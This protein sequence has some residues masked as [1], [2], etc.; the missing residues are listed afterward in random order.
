MMSL[1]Q[2]R[3]FIAIAETG[4]VSAAASA[5]YISQSTLTTAIKQLEEELGVGLFERHAKGMEL[6]HLGHQ[7]LRQAYLIMGSVENAKRSLQQSTDDIAGVLNVGVTSMVAGYYLADLVARFKRVYHNISVRVVEDEREYIE[8]LIIGGELDVAVLMLSDLDNHF[9]FNTEVLTYSR[10]HIWLPPEHALL[11]EESLNMKSVLEEPQILLSTDEME[12]RI[13]TIWEAQNGLP[14]IA[15]KSSSVEAVRS[16][17]SAG[18]GVAVMPEMAYRPWSVEGDRV[19]AKQILDVSNTLDIGLLWRRG[20]VRN[21]LINHFI[22]V[23]RESISQPT[24]SA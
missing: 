3:Y 11:K 22:E 24:F 6:T 12:R 18:M 14:N 5:V 23:A 4:S 15:M 10:Y 20:G 17:V 19:E 7:F 2:I 16:F 9:A 21:E 13:R 1:R 8:H